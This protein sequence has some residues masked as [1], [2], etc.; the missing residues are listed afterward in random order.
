MMERGIERDT[1]R[2]GER[3]R[4]GGMERDRG[5]RESERDSGWRM[6]QR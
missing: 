2:D 4:E 1:E 5:V 3:E 6:R